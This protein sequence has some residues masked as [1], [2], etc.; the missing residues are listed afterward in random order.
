MRSFLLDFVSWIKHF[1][2]GRQ[3]HLLTMGFEELISANCHTVIYVVV[4]KVIIAFGFV[5]I[6][7]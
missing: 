3:G 2:R 7:K 1:A 6:V 4:S 5:N